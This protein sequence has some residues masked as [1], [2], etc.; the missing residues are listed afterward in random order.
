[1][2]AAGRD[3]ERISTVLAELGLQAGR[4][5]SPGASDNGAQGPMLEIEGSWDVT[6]A[7]GLGKA[8]RWQGVSQVVCA[9]GSKFGRQQDGS[10]G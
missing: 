4:Q 5:P 8:Q 3:A 6:D 10:M 2:V 7:A 1:M 9:L